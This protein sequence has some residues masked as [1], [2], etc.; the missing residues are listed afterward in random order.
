MTLATLKL[1]RDQI[2]FNA[3]PKFSDVGD[4]HVP[5]ESMS[6]GARVEGRFRDGATRGERI[7]LIGESGCGKTSLVAYVL[8]PTAE[9]VAPILVPVHSLEHDATKETQVPDMIIAQLAR[10]AQIVGHPEPDTKGAIGRQ[11]EVRRGITRNKSFGTPSWVAS[12]EIAEQIIEQTTTTEMN[13]LE[14]KI[15]VIHQCLQPIH[16]DDLMPVFVFDDT[17][18]WTAATE[19][20]IVS[21]FFGNAIRWLAD[22]RASVV[23]ATNTRYLE[24]NGK[25]SDLLT[26]LDTRVELPRIPSA[27]QFARILHRRVQV[28]LDQTGVDG[29]GDQPWQLDDIVKSSAVEELF[30]Q[31]ERGASLRR[32]LKFAHMA[33]VETVDVGEH[34]ITGCGI[35]AAVQG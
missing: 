20:S 34:C 17:D 29:D 10:E 33:L 30:Q 2:A 25:N 35:R 18:R 28:H 22:L 1:L 19:E 27:D 14:D 8:G 16:A 32:V 12:A 9:S 6:T 3:T 4:Y 15:E 31:H 24:S 7:A 26:F 13:T 11:R 23:V 21:G 5:F